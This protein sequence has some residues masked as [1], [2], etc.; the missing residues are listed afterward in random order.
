MA[1]SAGKS[2]LSPDVFVR[3][4]GLRDGLQSIGPFMPTPQKKEWIDRCIIAG[5]REIEVCAFVPEKYIPQFR[6]A[7]EVA[8]HAA[9]KPDLVTSALVPNARGAVRALAAGIHRL[10]CIIS[11]TERF[12]HAN[13]RRSKAQSLA[14]L[15]SI[16]R[17]RDEH[18]QPQHRTVIQ[19]GISVAFGC[20]FEGIVPDRDVCAAAFSAAEAGADE[21]SLADTAGLGDPARVERIFTAVS[22]ELG[23]VPL[24]AH[25]HDTRG[26][27]LA[28]SL[29]ALYA[30]V[31]YF[32][33]SI[34]G[35]GGCPNAPGATGNIATEDLVFM[36]EAMGLDTGIDLQ[37]LLQMRSFV[38]DQ[39][40]ELHLSGH[41]DCAGIPKGFIRARHRGESHD[42]PRLLPA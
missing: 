8:R 39:L 30:G 12:S 26:M 11:A 42:E 6:D 41:L 16:L 34:G 28:N 24:G 5:L 20:P 38:A 2:D 31:R 29:A 25:F 18:A 36:L 13:L 19:V 22:R 10:V 37:R 35:L 15:E 21:I 1:E 17:L 32:D 4:V 23:K 14:E 33:A 9:L 7:E 3:E 40:P 27:G